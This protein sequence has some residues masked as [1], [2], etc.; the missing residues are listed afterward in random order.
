[1]GFPGENTGV[2]CHFLLQGIL[3]TQGSLLSPALAGRFFP[4]SA[5][6]KPGLVIDGL[7]YVERYFL[8]THFVESVFINRCW[9]LSNA[10]S[11]HMILIL[12]FVNDLLID[13][14]TVNSDC[15]PG[16][17]PLSN[18]YDPSF[19]F[20]WEFH[21]FSSYT[22]GFNP[23]WVN[24]CVRWGT[25][26]FFST[27]LCVISAP[28]VEKTLL[29]HWVILMSVLIKVLQRSKPIRCVC[30]YL[31]LSVVYRQTRWG[32]RKGE[33]DLRNRHMQ[34]GGWQAQIFRAGPQTWDSKERWC[35]RSGPKTDWRQN[36]LFLGGPQSVLF[37][38]STHWMNPSHI[39]EGNLLYSESTDL[40]INLI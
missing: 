6:G 15:V 37:R 30:V 21:G 35:G 33:R 13:L 38:A 34:F 5:T 27:W 29:S 25:V 17:T 4:T 22:E 32:E 24:L 11:A 16:M 31:C 8:S 20:L 12:H 23:V 19:V 3:L 28:F 1:M 14:Q 18:G 40:N 7:Y 36:S 9:I 39:V 10:F 2:G 26:S